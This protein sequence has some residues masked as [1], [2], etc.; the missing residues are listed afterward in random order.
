MKD[1]K[2]LIV[3]TGFQIEKEKY[4]DVTMSNMNCM[5]FQ[6]NQTVGN[7]KTKSETE[8]YINDEHVIDKIYYT[9]VEI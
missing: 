1:Q 3:K 2:E 5:L 4:L 7:N 8:L 9:L 6:N